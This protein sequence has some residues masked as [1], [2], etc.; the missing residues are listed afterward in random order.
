MTSR[1]SLFPATLLAIA[2]TA[3]GCGKD[4]PTGT[5]PPAPAP[6]PAAAPAATPPQEKA[7]A[8]TG[9]AAR[10]AAPPAAEAPSPAP[11][12]AVAVDPVAPGDERP[13]HPVS[14]PSFDPQITAV[15]GAPSLSA[16]VA[17]FARTGTE[18]G[19]GAQ[20]PPDPLA[21]ALEAVRMRLNLIDMA[22]LDPARPVR[23]AVP[24]PKTYPDGFLFV[25][26]VRGGEE[27][28]KKGLGDGVTAAPGHLGRLTVDG[29]ALYL[30]VLA[31]QLVVS[32]HDA[33]TGKLADYLTGVLLAWTPQDTVDVEVS[34]AHLR[35]AYAEELRSVRGMV[36][37]L[38]EQLSKRSSIPVQAATLRAVIDGAFGFI[39]GTDR[40]GVAV[41]P[42]GD[43]LQVAFGLRGVAGGALADTITSL[44]GREIATLGV[45]S[46]ATW[47]GIATSLPPA[48]T[49][50]DRSELLALF[51]GGGNAAF[52]PERAA[53][54]ADHALALSEVST[55]DSTVA[56][57]VDGKFPFAL[58]VLSLV[59]DRERA[60]TA[61]VGILEVVLE[62]QLEAARARLA[63]NAAEAR[64]K[65]ETLADLV[66]LGN[67]L[68]EPLGAK[69]EVVD[70]AR[71]D[72]H[73][74]AL[75]AHVDWERMGLA[76]SDPGFFAAVQA[77]VGAQ[78]GVALADGDGRLAMT[79]GPNAVDQA[80]AL[81][82]GKL[83]GGEP[84]LDRAGRGAVGAISLRVGAM[85][86]A[87]TA[88]PSLQS[89]AADYAK[90]PSD[91][92]ITLQARAHEGTLVITADV[93]LQLFQLLVR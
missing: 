54:L 87:L 68:G 50:F 24:D 6:A 38:G 48:L 84:N 58:S 44:D 2:L 62:L 19:A 25:L 90:I 79:L 86:Q 91:Q 64:F 59:S 93:A 43:R 85:L 11:A 72:V 80:V 17:A 26:P 88:L 75:V 51:T 4:E 77:M 83:P 40:V 10:P 23:L 35:A 92:A 18:L 32:S 16:L 81:A 45:A 34:V 71:G 30:D 69:L 5:A 89:R 67:T 13:L 31:D 65:L 74:K 60:R 41:A 70:E 49:R 52:T 66:T 36:G 33:L 57:G 1:R 20:V 82:A 28:V 9:E 27:A 56:V 29:R 21:A 76:R 22:W 14:L 47:L 12:P 61:M 8:D 3:A 15:A 7:A 46:A 53:R 39:E 73:V 78:V 63:E 37:A 55:G 42:N